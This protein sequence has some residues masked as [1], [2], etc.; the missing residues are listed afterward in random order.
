VEV[1][2]PSLDSRRPASPDHRWLDYTAF[3]LVSSKVRIDGRQWFFRHIIGLDSIG[4]DFKQG[5][6]FLDTGRRG[7]RDPFSPFI[8]MGR[9][10]APVF[11]I[12][13]RYVSTSALDLER[14]RIVVQTR[15]SSDYRRLE[16]QRGLVLPD[17]AFFDIDGRL[18]QL[19][20]FKGR[21]VLLNFWY[22]GCRPCLDEF[23]FL[24]EAVH[25]FGPLGLTIVGLS[26]SGQPEAIRTL[27]ASS[28]APW[29]EANPSSTR[30]IVEEWFHINARPAP[31]L[32]SPDGRILVLGKN[33]RSRLRGP[34]LVKTLGRML[35]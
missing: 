4:A 3:F 24:K 25:R 12:G 32:L 5:L 2:L 18:R 9:G 31:I 29:V 34:Q 26:T 14:R 11:R 17:F 7:R 6:Q 16:L 30:G 13:A 1:S 20:E 22:P 8:G 19:S 28:N 27:V 23:P 21:F 15:D 33:G 35:Q 10:E